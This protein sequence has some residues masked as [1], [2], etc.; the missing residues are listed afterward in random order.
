M[1]P[2]NEGGG[3]VESSLLEDAEEESGAAE[4]DAAG[5]SPKSVAKLISFRG[6]VDRSG[7]GD[8]DKGGRSAETEEV[9]FSSL[10]R[11]E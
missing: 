7:G 10:L 1:K 6:L 5:V 11:G 3:D 8:V 4:L 2:V 9:F